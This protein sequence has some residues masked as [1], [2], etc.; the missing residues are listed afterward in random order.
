MTTISG[1]PPRCSFTGRLAAA[2]GARFSGDLAAAAAFAQRALDVVVEDDPVRRYPMYALADVAL[3]EGRLAEAGRLY[4]AAADLA[5]DA[6]DVYF[7][8]YAMAGSSLPYAY[9]VL[10]H[11]LGVGSFSAATARGAALGDNGV[12]PFASEA[13]SCWKSAVGPQ[14]FLRST[15]K[16][17][18]S[19]SSPGSTSSSSSWRS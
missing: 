9:A 16:C 8:A 15:M 1:C 14:P 5:G 10:R 4:T 19:P 13:L 18:S 11:E 2:A 7:A 12:V 3:F 6:G 17:T